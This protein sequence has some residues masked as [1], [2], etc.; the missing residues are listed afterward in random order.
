MYSLLD[1]LDCQCSL[2]HIYKIA[3]LDYNLKAVAKRLIGPQQ[4]LNIIDQEELSEQDKRDEV[5]EMWLKVKGSNATYK[6]L[7]ALFQA[8]KCTETAKAV[9]M[10]VTSNAQSD[11][12][13][14][15]KRA[16]PLLGCFNYVGMVYI[17][18]RFT[19]TT[20]TPSFI[21]SPFI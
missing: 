18:H 19:L 2:E 15:M 5:F 14:L 9:R 4:A 21:S 8:L 12:N 13:E 1:P 17:W 6:E 10:L 16:L 20:T 11:G 3:S 7:V